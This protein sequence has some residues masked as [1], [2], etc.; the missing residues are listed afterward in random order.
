M[1]GLVI[2]LEG[3]P[4]RTHCPCVGQVLMYGILEAYQ[5]LSGK[6]LTCDEDTFIHECVVVT[7][8]DRQKRYL[9]FA[10]KQKPSS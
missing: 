7:D 5:V 10:V 9:R 2:E 1:P 6:E 3:V 8:I 4:M